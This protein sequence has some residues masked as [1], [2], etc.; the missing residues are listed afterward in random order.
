MRNL[1]KL[2]SISV[3]LAIIAAACA[4]AAATPTPVEVVATEVATKVATEIPVPIEPV[5]DLP[6][7]LLQAVPVTS[8]PAIDGNASDEQWKD[9]TAIQDGILTMKAVYTEK[10]IAFLMAWEDRDLSINT[11]GTWNWDPKVGNWWKTGVDKGIDWESFNGGRH[12]EWVN[13]AFDIS[14]KIS[15]EGC[16][17]FCHEYPPGSGIWHHQT[18]TKGEYVDSWFPLAKHGYGPNY[19]ED[20]GWLNGVRGVTQEGTLQFDNADPIDSHQ[21]LNGNITFL[22]YAEDKVMSSPDDLK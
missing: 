4:P 7:L 19:Y 8:L 5:A 3:C 9:A 15:S 21:L 11:R 1:L 17:A 20:Q 22:G 16:A 18:D 13:V 10:D 12:P 14:S 6:H 2:F